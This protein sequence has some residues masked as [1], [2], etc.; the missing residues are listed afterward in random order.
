MA[1]C[2]IDMISI[3]ICSRKADISEEL[4]QNI[5]KTIGCEYELCVIDN[6]RNEYS[7]FSAYNEGARRAKGDVLCFMHEDVL[8]QCEGWGSS[9]Y[10]HFQ[11]NPRTGAIGVAGGHYLPNRPCYWSEP[12]KESANYIQGGIRNGQYSTH[13]V[14]HQQY[15]SERTLVAAIDGVFMVMLKK[16][17]SD[18][19]VRWD[20]QTYHSF[21]FYD[22][23]MCMQ[24][25]QAGYEVEVVWDILLE[26]QSSGSFTVPF[27]KTR[28]VWY[29]KWKSCLPVVQGIEMTQE[30]YEI[31]ENIMDITDDSHAYY[32]LQQSKAYRLGRFLL[33]PN[34]A[35]LKKLFCKK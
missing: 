26:H 18:G 35:N 2:K 11:R 23:D 30:D 10:N 27:I 7:I 32:M 17:F 31:C 28:Q 24:I 21:H 20:E 34:R 9:L 15:R 8:F 1:Y 33:H 13:R 19:L 5:A 4:K 29:N 16:L 14:L 22:A 6:S 12:R 3:I 25:H